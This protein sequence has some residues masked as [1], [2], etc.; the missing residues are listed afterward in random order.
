[1]SSVRA[2]PTRLWVLD[3]FIWCQVWNT[4]FQCCL[5]GFMWG[6][7]RYTRPSWST[8]FFVA[9]AC[10]IAGVG[11][12]ASFIEGRKVKRVEGV[13]PSHPDSTGTDGAAT[14]AD[15]GTRLREV[16][17]GATGHESIHV[18]EKVKDRVVR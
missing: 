15:H 1:M 9:L 16:N 14:G 3:F 13:A 17:T 5:C 2:P 12:V 8:G 18:G 4:F 7:S 6:M 11:G 10:I